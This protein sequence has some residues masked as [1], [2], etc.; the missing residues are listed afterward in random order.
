M[1]KAFILEHMLHWLEVLSLLRVMDSGVTAL[2]T[3]QS[4]VKVVRFYQYVNCISQYTVTDDAY[5]S[6]SIRLPQSYVGRRPSIP[7]QFRTPM[8]CSAAHIYISALAFCPQSTSL[9]NIF[10]AR[11]HHGV[12]CVF[13]CAHAVDTMLL[14]NLRVTQ[15]PF[16]LSHF[17]PMA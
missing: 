8:V 16:I 4:W 5:S 6:R 10:S 1:V 11:Y 12:A 14:P 13:W 17:R 15:V 2:K 7:R 9:F 3:A